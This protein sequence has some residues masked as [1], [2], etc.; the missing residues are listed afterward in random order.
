MKRL[1]YIISTFLILSVGINAPFVR[2]SSTVAA[3]GVL[4]LPILIKNSAVKSP[5][6]NAVSAMTV[7]RPKAGDKWKT[8]KLY[9]VRWVKGSLGGKVRIYLY[10]FGTHYRTLVDTI[11]DGKYAWK[12]PA[13]I[14][15]NSKY[16]IV[17]QS[18][19]D[20]DIYDFSSYFTITKTSTSAGGYKI[21][22]T[23][24]GKKVKWASKKMPYYINKKGGPPGAAIAIKKGASVW[25]KVGGSAFKF[26]YRGK[27]GSRG[28]GRNDGVNVVSF[29]LLAL[30]VVGQNW[31]WYS[32]ST[33]EILDS[34]IR[35]STR[36][37]WSTKKAKNAYDVQSIAAHELGHS[38]CLKDLYGKADKLKTMY[39]YGSYGDTK[40]RTLHPADKRGI[41]ALY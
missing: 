26:I 21:C 31:Y 41:R 12:I 7:T 28:F 16:Q 39:G 15:S 32:T 36:Y 10:R 25:N 14:A 6:V 20:G 2:L 4:K 35:F 40:S 22:K 27:T 24:S 30:G 13:N 17:V 1:V 19:V 29:G 5:T 3:A 34:D 11:N 18:W 9:P 33:G 38:L 8:G 23:D 37:R